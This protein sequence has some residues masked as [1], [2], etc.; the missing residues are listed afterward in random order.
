MKN[1]TAIFFSLFLFLSCKSI[2]KKERISSWTN[3]IRKGINQYGMKDFF[4]FL[5]DEKYYVVGTEYSS[6]YK[7]YLGPVLYQSK[8]LSKWKKE[9]KLLNPNDIPVNAWYKDGW[10]APEI[11]KIKNKYYFSFNNRNNAVNPY[12]KL[13]FGIAV[14]NELKGPYKV[15]NTKTPLTLGNHGSLV[16]GENE[17]EI[18][19]IYDNDARIYS[20]KVD[21]EKG[22]L[23]NEPKELLGPET[24]GKNY[25]YLD[26]PQ[27]TK[28]GPVYHMLFSQFYGG[29]EVKVFHMT[30]IHPLGPW[31]WDDTNP[32]YSFLEAEAD[33]VVKNKYPTRHGFAPPTQVVFSNQLFLGKNNQYF[34]AYHSSEKYS[35]PYLC[36]EPVEVDGDRI[37]IPTAKNKHQK[38]VIK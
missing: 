8:N 9:I 37:Y 17:D 38:E 26:A 10:F 2:P 28:V 30:A 31:K 16:V 33:E 12:Q 19:L 7:G 36:I 5:E 32:L 27:I 24:L 14:S 21:I 6:P 34:N 3:P 11:K 15:I 1:Y 25:K 4:V 13:G 20:V 22:I 29:Y 35:E 18:F 23:K